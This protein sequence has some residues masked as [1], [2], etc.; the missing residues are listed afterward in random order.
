[1][2]IGPRIGI[3][4]QAFRGHLQQGGGHEEAGA[5]R[6]E[7]AQVALDA[8]GAHQHQ[9]AGHVGQ[10]GDHAEE[11]GELEHA[12]LPAVPDVH[13]VAVLHHVFLAFEAQACPGRAQQLLNRRQA[14]CPSEWFQRG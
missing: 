4:A 2:R 11:D 1:M 7:V 9:A 3:Q 12:G 13:H 6:D 8:A 10:R 14:D 5:E